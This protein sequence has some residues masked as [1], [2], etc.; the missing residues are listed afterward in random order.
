MVKADVK[1]RSTVMAISHPAIDVVEDCTVLQFGKPP[2]F[3]FPKLIPTSLKPL[4][5]QYKSLFRN[6]PGSTTAAFHYIPTS[7]APVRLPPHRIP[8]HYKDVVYEQ[9]HLMLEQ[10]IIEE[11]SSPWMASAVFVPKKSGE[12]RLC[13]DYRELN[14]RTT[15]DAYPLP[16][17][18]EVQ[19][20][21][22]NCSVFSMLD[23]QSGYWQLPVN[24][25]DYHKTNFC[26]GQEWDYTTLSG[27]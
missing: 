12:I 7:G 26:P 24:P 23:L 18:D 17:V 3:E 1:A 5:H 22:A 25:D 13:I 16:L 20:C 8:A 11:S 6:I 21:L 10:D 19:E 2:S 15:K 27:C 14:K 9:L 4:V